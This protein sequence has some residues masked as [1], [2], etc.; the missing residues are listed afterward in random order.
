MA[1]AM[2]NAGTV[3]IGWW[4]RTVPMGKTSLPSVLR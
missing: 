2:M 1:T 3:A 4:V